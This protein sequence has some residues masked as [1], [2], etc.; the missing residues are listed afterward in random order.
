MEHEKNCENPLPR[1]FNNY[2]N[3]NGMKKESTTT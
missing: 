3:A 2:I 1:E